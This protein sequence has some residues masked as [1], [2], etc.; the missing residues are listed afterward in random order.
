MECI[1]I[2]EI[3]N[4]KCCSSSDNEANGD[5]AEYRR[6]YPKL[7]IIRLVWIQ[8]SYLLLV[9]RYN[10]R[11]EIYVILLSKPICLLDFPLRI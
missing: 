7:L 2:M 4:K 1:S 8:F 5:L 9:G 3:F 10:L 6:I 11:Q